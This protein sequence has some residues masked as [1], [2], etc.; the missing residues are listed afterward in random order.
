[1]T[2]NNSVGDKKAFGKYLLSALTGKPAL[3]LLVIGLASLV[4]Y[5]MV[6]GNGGGNNIVIQGNTIAIGIN[7]VVALKPDGSLWFWGPNDAR[8]LGGTVLTE[9]SLVR[10]GIEKGWVAV[11]A[12]SYKWTAL[13]ADGSLWAWGWGPYGG[14]DA[15]DSLLTQ[16]DDQS[17]NWATVSSRYDHTMAIKSDG[18][19]W[20]WVYNRSGRLGEPTYIS[21][22]V[23]TSTD[24]AAVSPGRSHTMAIKTDGSLWAWGSNEHG[25]LGNGAETKHNA[26][27]C[28]G[29]G[30]NWAAV[31]AGGS[32]TMA[33]KSDGSLWA[34]GNNEHGQLGDGTI[35]SR[36]APVR[37]GKETGWAAVSAGFDYTVALK[38]DG[39]LWAWGSNEWG[40]LG[41]IAETSQWAP[42]RVGTATDWA[43]V[44]A[45]ANTTLGIKADGTLW[46]WGRVDSYSK[47]ITDQATVIQVGTGFRVPLTGVGGANNKIDFHAPYFL[48]HPKD[49][50]VAPGQKTTLVATA[51]GTP[52]HSNQWQQSNDGG[53]TWDNISG[54]TDDA[55][56]TAALAMGDSGKLYRMTAT[57][58]A[59]STASD[60]A[61]VWVHAKTGWA[62]VSAGEHSMALLADGSLWA[63][64]KNDQGQIGNATNTDQDTLARVGTSTDWTAI[65]AGFGY[66]VALKADGSLWVWGNKGYGLGDYTYTNRNA[67]IQIGTVSDWKA[68]SADQNHIVA[69]KAN[70]SLWTWGSN[71]FGQLGNGRRGRYEFQRA[72]ERIGVASD[73]KAVSAGSGHTVAI[74]TDGSLWTWGDNGAGQLGVGTS[75][76][77]TNQNAPIR[78][79]AAT[80][81][82]V[83]SAGNHFTMALKTDGS[84]W[85]WGA[86]RLGNGAATSQKV[87]VQ[88]GTEKVW[89]AVSAG[90]NHTMAL[91]KDGSLWAWGNNDMGQ[92]GDGT[93]ANRNA[94]VQI[95]KG[96][97]WVAVS[98]GLWHT[99][100]V[101]ADGSLWAWGCNRDGRLGD[102]TNRGRNAPV[103]IG[104]GSSAPGK[105]K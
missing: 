60:P 92:L 1:M 38:N 89:A 37:L 20:T 29:G 71:E 10:V 90:S 46:L 68:I 97:Y 6:S 63:W 86:G 73:W 75:G 9:K 21:V 91:K 85:A 83:I 30:K 15:R 55:Y 26:P 4:T 69:I 28:I 64:G 23:G 27:V 13:K 22:Q 53:T 45:G 43:S 12:G 104:M 100:A 14:A 41:E 50:I 25:Q 49:C 51:S 39:S 88:I 3:W 44:L 81:W 105:S 72:P 74:K 52:T 11:S 62:V 93:K 48:E 94:P 18:S 33:I 58:A 31:S 98:A 7:N 65:S 36:K 102:G 8:G 57:N 95:D 2:N 78:V 34:W 59:G 32:H 17:S 24:W 84:L 66:A 101:K 35:K 56:T 96:T 76:Y 77:G 47:Q 61:T 5:F 82:Q 80:D 103:R 54:A 87:P 19:L 40:Q 42:A 16:V 79:G 99:L 67:P 70:G